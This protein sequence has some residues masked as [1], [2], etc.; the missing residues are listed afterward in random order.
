[1]AGEPTGRYD[2]SFWYYQPAEDRLQGHIAA[3]FEQDREN[4]GAGYNLKW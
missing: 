4:T 2:S 1:L 3:K